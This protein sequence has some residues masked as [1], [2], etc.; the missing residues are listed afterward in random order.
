[1]IETDETEYRMYYSCCIGARDEHGLR[2]EATPCISTNQLH[3]LL[4]VPDALGQVLTQELGTVRAIPLDGSAGHLAGALQ[5]NNDRR[6]KTWI[7]CLMA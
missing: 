1:V 3:L 2:G 7:W 6:G 4:A 5:C